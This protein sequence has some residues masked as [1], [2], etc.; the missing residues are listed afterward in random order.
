MRWADGSCEVDLGQYLV[1][2]EPIYKISATHVN[3]TCNL[4]DGSITFT[5]QDHPNKNGL[6]FCLDGGTN[7]LPV[8]SDLIGSKTYENLP[9]DTYVL[10]ARWD[11]G[12]CETAI[13]TTIILTD[14]DTDFDGVC[15]AVDSCAGYDD[16]LDDDG[17]NIP[18][19]CDLCTNYWEDLSLPNLTINKSAKI[20]VSTN[21][22]ISNGNNITL[23]AG[24]TIHLS[25]GFSVEP[26]A[27]FE[28]TI[29]PCVD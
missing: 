16:N 21:G 25:S 14:T 26:G 7:F 9:S 3:E 28:A 10:H 29:E 27:E 15:D 11:D 22:T 2:A 19:A 18:D 17:D 6:Q 1:A 8:V 20:Q 23:Q 13:G 4:N 24:D 5:F 12:S